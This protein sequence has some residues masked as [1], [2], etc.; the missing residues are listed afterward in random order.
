MDRTVRNLLVAAVC[1]LVLG[2]LGV[3]AALRQATRPVGKVQV[4]VANEFDNFFISERGVTAL[5]TNGGQ[6]QDLFEALFRELFADV[7]ASE[8]TRSFGPPAEPL[9]LPLE[10]RAGSY[11]GAALQ[12]DAFMEG[13]V[14]RLRISMLGA[15]A[16]IDPDP[17]QEYDLTPVRADGDTL[18]YAIRFRGGETWSPVTFY[19]A[20]SGR[21]YAHFGARA[22][23][24]VDA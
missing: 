9:A 15:L 3:F 13:A 1:L 4:K 10:D 5:L 20:D 18:V 24:E 19:R 22:L 23:P 12:L 11:R 2:G 16:A 6:A 17:V 7:A 14:P 8:A 21:A